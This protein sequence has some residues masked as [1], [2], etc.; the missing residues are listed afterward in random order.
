MCGFIPIVNLIVLTKLMRLAF[1][2]VSL[3]MKKSILP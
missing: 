1:N 3:K 2:E